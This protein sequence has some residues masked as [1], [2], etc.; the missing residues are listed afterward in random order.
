M[1][2]STLA[3]AED[4]LDEIFALAKA[5]S[6]RHSHLQPTL[7]VIADH[8]DS[9]TGIPTIVIGELANTIIKVVIAMNKQPETQN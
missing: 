6:A 4:D 1:T 3:E 2:E 5:W 9:I 7:I 8:K